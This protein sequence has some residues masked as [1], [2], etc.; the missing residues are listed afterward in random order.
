MRMRNRAPGTMVERAHE[1]ERRDRWWHDTFPVVVG[2]MLTHGIEA[3][4]I[5]VL[6]G[7]AVAFAIVGASL[8]LEFGGQLLG[9][10]MAVAIRAIDRVVERRVTHHPTS[11][12]PHG[13]LLASLGSTALGAC[14]TVLCISLG[15]A[16]LPALFAGLPLLAVGL[17]FHRLHEEQIAT[18]HL[19]PPP[20]KSTPQAANRPSHERDVAGFLPHQ[21]PL[22]GRSTP[23]RYSRVSTRLPVPQS[24]TPQTPTTQR[25]DREL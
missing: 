12:S 16:A 13:T 9:R 17:G 22:L 20:P 7:P 24:T 14:L 6:A 25:S 4:V 2:A 10:P 5:G 15:L 18:R 1:D 21:I 3:L 8:G 11:R 23:T 19:P